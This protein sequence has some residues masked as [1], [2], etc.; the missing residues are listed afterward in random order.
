MTPAAP[1]PARRLFFALWPDEAARRALAR[2]TAKA[3]R[4]CGGRPVPAE[5]LHVTLAFLGSVAQDRIPHLQCSAR[6][7]ATTFA[8][9]PLS[10]RFDRLVHWPRQQI[11][12]AL[13]GGE[14][15]AAQALATALRATVAAAGFSPDLKPFD[16]HVTVAR[17]VARPPAAA[18]MRPVAWCFES[19]ALLDS[20]TESAGPVYSVIESY[21]LVGSEKAGK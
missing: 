17:K 13:A 16:V 1:E 4:H 2:A 14:S 8:A 11:L 3:V 12:C 6:G 20:R 18:A 15:P 5:N 9:G 21:P 7:L 10:L 19:F